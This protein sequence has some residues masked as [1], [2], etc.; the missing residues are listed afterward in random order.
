MTNGKRRRQAKLAAEK[1]AIKRRLEHAVAINA[2]GL[3]LGRA[4]I[5]YEL[6]ERTRGTAHGGMGMIAELVGAL[7]LADEIDSSLHLLKLHKPGEFHSRCNGPAMMLGH[8]RTSDQWRSAMSG[9]P[10]C[11]EEREEIR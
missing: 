10:L 1:A 6:A 3:V 4:N 7:G 11:A 8:Y 9:R 2:D 5:A